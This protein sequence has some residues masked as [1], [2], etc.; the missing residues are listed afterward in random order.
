[1][2]VEI[3]VWRE[4]KSSSSSPWII[5]VI[6]WK[7]QKNF[8]LN[9]WEVTHKSIGNSAK[10]NALSFLDCKTCT[11]SALHTS[12]RV[13][14]K[15]SKRWKHYVSITNYSFVGSHLLSMEFNA[16]RHQFLIKFAT[17]LF[18]FSRRQRTNVLFVNFFFQFLLNRDR[19]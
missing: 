11:Q 9:L 5:F 12:S 17:K 1:M 13:L 6:K 19:L 15:H 14:S 8:F 2:N 16:P 18:I 7:G 4:W 3:G 10:W